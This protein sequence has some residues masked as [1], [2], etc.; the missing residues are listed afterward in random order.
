MVAAELARSQER[1]RYLEQEVRARRQEPQAAALPVEL[2]DETVARLLGEETTRILQ[3]ARESSAATRA[4]AEE[5]ADRLLRD[6]REEAQRMREDI[7][8]SS[9][10]TRSCDC[11]SACS[12]ASESPVWQSMAS[13]RRT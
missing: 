8:P 11:A 10:S 1:E 7:E 13:S 6:A 2:D 9:F 5:A 3:A 4:K 12:R